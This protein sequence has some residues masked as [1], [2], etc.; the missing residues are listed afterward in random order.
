LILLNI[1]ITFKNFV[2]KTGQF[3]DQIGPEG[4]G[5]PPLTHR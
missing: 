1:I 4:V 2:L 5:W 3:I